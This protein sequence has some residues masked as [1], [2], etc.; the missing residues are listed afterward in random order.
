M[1]Q[2][3][4]FVRHGQSES[5]VAGV[6]AGSELDKPLT[7]HG[8]EQAREA[9]SQLRSKQVDMIVCSP[10]IRTRQTAETIAGE[11]GFDST[12]ILESELF[13]ERAYGPYSGI[14][15]EEYTQDLEADTLEPGV[16]S[17]EN[18]YARVERGTQ[19]LKTLPYQNIVLVS[20]GGVGRMVKVLMR[21]LHHSTHK[22]IDRVG[23]AEI[24]EFTL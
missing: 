22:T 15:Y 16:E 7:A 20:H 17:T 1:T 8:V 24:Y 19:W 18:L 21:N 2:T 23:N 12:Q 6:M 14:S 13:V 10:M 4:Y 11:L 5:N 9:G 3:I